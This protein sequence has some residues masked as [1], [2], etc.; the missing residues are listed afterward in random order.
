MALVFA[1]RVKVR[2][3]TAGTGTFTLENTVAG[4]QS[5]SVI[6]DGNQTYYGIVDV[7]GNWEIGLGTYT[8][9]GTTLSRD[10]VVSSSNNDALVNF[11]AGSKNVYTTIPSAL[12]GTIL[13]TEIIQVDLK[14]SVFADTSTMLIDGTEGKINLDGTV[15]GDIIP[16]QD[17]AYDI[18]SATYRFRDIYLSGSTIN[19]G[20]AL[21]TA[22]EDGN[23]S[24]PGVTETKFRPLSIDDYRQD[25]EAF[26]NGTAIPE[27]SVIIDQAT[28]IWGTTGGNQFGGTFQPSVYSA[29]F[30]GSGFITNISIVEANYYDDTNNWVTVNT[31]NM[32]VVPAGTLLTAE[33]IDAFA[34]SSG[35]IEVLNAGVIST[36]DSVPDIPSLNIPTDVSQLSDTSSILPSVNASSSII[37]SGALQLDFSN[38]AIEV[39]H[40]ED[41][42]SITA[43]PAPAPG[44]ARTIT[45]I[46]T[47]DITG[48]RTI[49]GNFFTSE[50][51][52]LNIN[53]DSLAVNIVTFLTLDGGATFYAFSNG[54]NF[55]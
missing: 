23:I 9:S 54:K 46:L 25:G 36:S 39:T 21:I 34:Q 29:T 30:N 1:D 15:K 17:V 43:N 20:G 27:D 50:G 10:Q 33:S 28:W 47:Q 52:G 12:V 42:T 31:D 2:A 53:T 11:P 6:G 18:G 38:S 5:F 44:Q 45:V 37:I 26:F 32:Y 41:I 40:D 48:G 4:F 35:P 8:S 24:I 49:S 16:D 14:G 55:L 13:G 19:L 7:A 51:L 3:R 22:T